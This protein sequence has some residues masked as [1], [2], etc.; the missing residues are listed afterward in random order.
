VHREAVLKVLQWLCTH[1]Q[2]YYNVVIDATRLSALPEEDILNYS[3]E[4]VPLSTV[5]F[6][7]FET[8]RQRLS[9]KRPTSQ[10]TK[11]MI[12]K[13]FPITY[14]IFTPSEPNTIPTAPN[15]EPTSA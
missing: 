11:N 1:N 15:N 6:S 8:L 12:S 7:D 4:H 3:V 2:L 9:P 14:L 10:I 5:T 13:L